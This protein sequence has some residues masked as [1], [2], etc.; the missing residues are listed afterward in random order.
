MSARIHCYTGTGN[1]LWVARLLAERLPGS[2]LLPLLPGPTSPDS[3][4]LVLVFPVH[5]WGLPPR[6]E[7]F[8]QDPPADLPRC[9]FAVAVNAGQVV[10]TLV[11]LDRLLRRRGSRLAAGF[12]VLM[13]SNYAPFGGPGS[14]ESQESLFSAARRKVEY[15]AA[16]V[17]GG[18]DHPPERSSWWENA[19]FPPLNRLVAPLTPRMDYFF[20]A[21]GRCNG[22]GV[23]ARVCPAGNIRLESGRPLWL[24]HCEQ[25]WSCFH[26]CP[27][28]AIQYGRLTENRT[29]YHHPQVTVADVVASRAGSRGED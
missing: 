11:R 18:E 1:S 24:H 3:S 26:W 8:V 6:V 28:Q 16:V 21:D 7:A 5:M 14:P 2:R 19:V 13:P 27:E 15:I 23:C 29:R 4:A 17:G 12:S 25:C 10:R 20:R 9:V 22:C